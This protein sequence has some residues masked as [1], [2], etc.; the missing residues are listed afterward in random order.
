MEILIILKLVS[1][2]LSIWGDYVV[3][4]ATFRNQNVHWFNLAWASLTT[5]IFISIQFELF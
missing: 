4:V 5:T 1:L 2:F 3:L